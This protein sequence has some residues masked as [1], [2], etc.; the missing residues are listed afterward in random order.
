MVTKSNV[1]HLNQNPR[2]CLEARVPRSGRQGHKFR[3]RGK[4]ATEQGLGRT[5]VS[6]V[7]EKLTN[8]CSTVEER[9]FSA[10]Y[11]PKISPGFSAR[12]R[13]L[14]LQRVFPQPLER[15]PLKSLGKMS[16]L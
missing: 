7:A 13:I 10:A 2:I 9:R 6:E 14:C 8:A 1:T 16:A 5:R 11:S 4:T 15:V 12:G 3:R